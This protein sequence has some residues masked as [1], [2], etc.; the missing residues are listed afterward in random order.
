MEYD[1]KDHKASNGK[2]IYNE[3]GGKT[4]GFFFPSNLYFR[5]LFHY[6]VDS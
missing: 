2:G 3:D 4:L 1:E 6:N 5:S